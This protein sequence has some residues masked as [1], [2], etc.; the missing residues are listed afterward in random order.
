MEML[1]SVLDIV[2]YCDHEAYFIQTCVVTERFNGFVC[3]VGGSY[4]P[5]VLDHLH[6]SIYFQ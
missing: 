5:V 6:P 3:F 2:E 1:I 4:N